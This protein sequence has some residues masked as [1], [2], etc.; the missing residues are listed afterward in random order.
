[1]IYR[2]IYTYKNMK[3]ILLINNS[4]ILYER[5]GGYSKQI[6]YLCKMLKDFNYE[7]Y[8]LMFTMVIRNDTDITQLYSYYELKSIIN[9]DQRMATIKV[10]EKF[11]TKVSSKSILNIWET[12]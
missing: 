9:G 5:H 4:T 8:N 12:N 10:K 2:S 7:I 1:M 11:N 6:Y 3:K